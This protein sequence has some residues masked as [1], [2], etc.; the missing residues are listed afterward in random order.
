MRQ[1]RWKHVNTVIEYI[2]AAQRFEDNAADIAIKSVNTDQE[3][4]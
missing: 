2:E 3:S 1:G 4:T